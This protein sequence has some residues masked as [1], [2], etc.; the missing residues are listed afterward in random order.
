VWDRDG[1]V[2]I[3]DH[4]IFTKDEKAHRNV[5]IL[6]EFAS[7][8]SL[9]HLYD[10]GTP[11]YKGVCHIALAE[12][13]HTR[14]ARCSSAPTPTPAR[15]APSTSSRPGIGNTDA[16]FVMGTGKLLLKVPPTMRFVFDGELPPYVLA[17]DLILQIIGDI[18]V[19]G[20]HRTGRWSSPA[21]R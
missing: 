13:G 4:Y 1:V 7:E 5:D 17:K 9:P 8:Q 14:P 12:E 20:R 2:L 21:R 6:R 18:G 16:A 19:D 15:R 11:R 10:V 3:P